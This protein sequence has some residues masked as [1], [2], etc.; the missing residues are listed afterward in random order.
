MRDGSHSGKSRIFSRRHIQ[1]CKSS[2]NH[3][4]VLQWSF[5]TDDTKNRHKHASIETINR[6]G[7]VYTIHGS[8]ETLQPVLLTAHQDV[9][10]VE[11]ETLNQWEHPPFDAYYN[12]T[13]GYLWGRGATDK[14]SVTA[15]MTAMEALLS[16]PE[17]DPRR[18][19][20]FAFGFDEE[21]SGYRGAGRIS[22]YLEEQYGEGGIAVIL[23]EGGAGVQSLGDTMYAL[24]A[25]YEKGY[26]DV[27]FDLDVLGGHSATPTPHTALGIMS[28]IVVNLESHPFE[29]K[30]ERNSPVHQTLA[31]LARYSSDL[32]PDLADAV[33]RGDLRSAAQILAQ[34][35]KE[36][37]Y[38]IQTS[39]A[40]DFLTGGD[41]INSLP[42]YV[43][44][45]VNHRYAPQD[46]VG[47]I[48]HRI[49]QLAKNTSRRYNLE[50][51]PFEG[52]EDYEA[53]LAA[54]SLTRDDDTAQGPWL[55][56]FSG[57]L[58]VETKKRSYITPQAPTKGAVWDVF[59]G[60][61]RHTFADDSP[62]VV[63]AP[64]AMTAN[65]DTQHY[66]SKSLFESL[67]ADCLS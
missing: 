13:D 24:P 63:V 33:Y 39:Q 66:L 41:K 29:P 31:C 16:Q 60:T 11:Q 50:F 35:S 67:D 48:Q 17:Y 44:L 56:T 37:Q 26:L 7:L 27:W 12:E 4:P 40:V 43:T 55:P 30:I 8:D 54:H 15:L 42:E 52:D 32:L 25:V 58:K 57:T 49:V 1:W 61:V 36:T 53:Y 6:F 3:F 19:V 62:T 20:I 22:K 14:A 59:A 2:N 23:D 18:T 64:G 5:E 45:G 38:L 47:S 28:E 21:C 9:V 51:K 10:P 65:T 34:T 46:S